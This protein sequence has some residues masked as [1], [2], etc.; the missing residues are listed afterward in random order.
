MK[1]M[2]ERC[3]PNSAGHL[4]MYSKTDYTDATVTFSETKDLAM[5]L[6]YIRAPLGLVSL[7]ERSMDELDPAVLK[8]AEIQHRLNPAKFD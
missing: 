6:D 1:I 8:I 3:H 7:F 2:S 5:V 4:F